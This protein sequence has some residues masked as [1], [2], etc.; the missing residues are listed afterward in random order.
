M[1]DR[2]TALLLAAS[3][4]VAAALGATA[5]VASSNASGAWQTA[6]RRQLEQAD[7]VRAGVEEVYLREAPQSV[8]VAAARW[9]AE[10]LTKAA[11]TLSGSDRD[12]ALVEAASQSALADRLGGPA[13]IDPGRRLAELRGPSRRGTPVPPR[14]TARGDHDARRAIWLLAATVPVGVAFL[15]G[16][17]GA[18]FVRAGVVFLAVGVVAGVVAYAA[19]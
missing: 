13:A 5:S 17:L 4:V 10:E 18:R 19:R 8:S 16:A 2:S 15:M 6:V 12:A 11:A 9:R 1:A 3:A 14:W 7:A